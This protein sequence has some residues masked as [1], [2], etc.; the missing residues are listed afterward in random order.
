[1]EHDKLEEE[2]E[3]ICYLITTNSKGKKAAGES[4]V[5]GNLPFSLWKGSR[6]CSSNKEC[7]RLPQCFALCDATVAVGTYEGA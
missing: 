4:Q 5:L 1:M 2:G 6:R 3:I 7:F